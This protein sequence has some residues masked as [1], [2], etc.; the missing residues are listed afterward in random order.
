MT[1]CAASITDA[2]DLIQTLVGAELKPVTLPPVANYT[3]LASLT[4]A[5]EAACNFTELINS[6]AIDELVQ[7][8]DGSWP[9]VFRA[10]STIPASD[11]LRAQ[12]VRTQLMHEMHDA[13]REVDVLVTIPFV[14]PQ[15]AYTN[16]C[17]QPSVVTRCGFV[18]DRP[19][20]IEFVGQLYRED[21]VLLL[22]HAVEQKLKLAGKWMNL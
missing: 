12:Q 11:Y 22:A 21:Q 4:I 3:G 8:D 9:N 20:M 13:M 19:K 10:G 17:G 6:P 16:L 15:S 5:A 2:I 1:T 18:G 14:G 7:Q